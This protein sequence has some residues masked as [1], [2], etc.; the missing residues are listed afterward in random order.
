MKR[1]I[2]QIQGQTN[3]VQEGFKCC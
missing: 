2:P 1:V 3:L